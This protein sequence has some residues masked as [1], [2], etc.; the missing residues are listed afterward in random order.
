MRKII[1]VPLYARKILLVPV[2]VPLYERKFVHV[3]I[4]IGVEFHLPHLAE[5]CMYQ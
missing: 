3:S 2:S 1:H 5:K 4:S